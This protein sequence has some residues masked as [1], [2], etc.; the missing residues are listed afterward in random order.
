[1][2]RYAG[3]PEGSE[4]VQY[5]GMPEGAE[6]V[7][8]APTP[9]GKSAPWY[10]GVAEGIRRGGEQLVQ[11]SVDA[12]KFGYETGASL[13][14]APIQAWRS[15]L[16][17]APRGLAEA[18][19]LS[20]YATKEYPKAAAFL[21]LD[22]P[23]QEKL[24]E[25][26]NYYVLP[27][28]IGELSLPSELIGRGAE[29]AGEKA[30]ISPQE[31]HWLGNAMAIGGIRGGAGA[32]GDVASGARSL[33]GAAR[34]KLTIPTAA[35]RA[36]QVYRSATKGLEPGT[37]QAASE[38]AG[39]ALRQAELTQ[40]QRQLGVPALPKAASPY[41]G[42][43]NLAAG[44]AAASKTGDVLKSERQLTQ[45]AKEQAAAGLER[46]VPGVEINPMALEFVN[47]KLEAHNQRLV[48]AEAD[49][50]ATAKAAGSDAVKAAKSEFTKGLEAK[51]EAALASLDEAVPKPGQKYDTFGIGES[52]LKRLRGNPKEAIT[53]GKAAVK[54]VFDAEYA[55]FSDD[56]F[57][58][59]RSDTSALKAA[60][61]QSDDMAIAAG[62]VMKPLLGEKFKTVERRLAGEFVDPVTDKF[63]VPDML[64]LGQW[65][66]LKGAF[67]DAASD[68][69][70]AREY[71]AARMYGRMRE[72][73]EVGE[74]DA[75]KGLGKEMEM[76]YREVSSA[77]KNV[78]DRAFRSGQGE[79]LLQQGR[80]FVEGGAK[81]KLRMEDV[82]P[83][84]TA[85]LSNARDFMAAL[86]AEKLGKGKEGFPYAGV[87]EA[88]LI[89]AGR[90][91]AQAIVRPYIESK[92][93]TLYEQG[94]GGKKGMAKVNTFLQNE[95]VAGA[96]RE[97]GIDLSRLRTA[98]RTYN[99]TM[100]Q[101][102]KSKSEIANG[103]VTDTLSSGKG[104]MEQLPT[105][106]AKVA[107]YVL[108]APSP[109]DAYSNLMSVSN[110]PLWKS[111]VNTLVRDELKVRVDKGTD[112][113]ANAN[114]R[115]AME[116]IYTPEQVKS[117]KAYHTLMDTL[118][119]KPARFAGEDL[120]IHPGETAT[121]LGQAIPVGFGWPL[122]PLKHGMKQLAGIVLREG[123]AAAYALL[124][125]ALIDNP[126]M[127]K[128]IVDAYKGRVAAQIAVKKHLAEYRA[129]MKRLGD[130]ITEPTAAKAGVAVGAAVGGREGP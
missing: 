121:K 89:E 44:R 53:T 92:V 120:S 64:T 106:P 2:P 70:F 122:Y 43:Q 27:P 18:T 35:Q 19:G 55:K 118:K 7:Q 24:D 104:G 103:V 96:L 124:D 9:G 101:L 85:K 130:A 115:A 110:D 20:E 81:S 108:E 73:M 57:P 51:A 117:L 45:T 41:I 112:I 97:Y 93:A 91:Q 98:A 33:C 29:W 111:S 42:M 66:G 80:Q 102:T 11:S 30:G 50:A 113:F 3:M 38:A 8:E 119:E 15:A 47:K 39:I 23:S 58:A 22:R 78:Y 40:A 56:K 34:N 16:E 26:S 13:V 105:A 94:G 5:A 86:G 123:D 71:T 14:N 75:A 125:G 12:A 82:I 109:K 69:S 4:V 59:A 67:R 61:A 126:G 62:Q 46:T 60:F 21:G 74:M 32:V 63:A 114:T 49:A 1:M 129:A 79:T 25:I 54:Q 48:T 10:S 77:Y 100:A 88:N 107:G 17:Y 31:M 95:G 6:V 90:P 72:L 84:L 68:A 36:G 37:S 65:K 76:Q 127:A 83:S 87:S 128:L 99:E 52:L 116:A 28:T